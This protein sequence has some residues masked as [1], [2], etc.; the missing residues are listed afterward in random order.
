MCSYWIIQ[1]PEESWP[2]NAYRTDP[3]AAGWM[4]I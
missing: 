2:G 1:N 4:S 3:M